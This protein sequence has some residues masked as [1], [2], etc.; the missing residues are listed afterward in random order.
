MIVRVMSKKM[1]AVESCKEDQDIAKK[2]KGGARRT[3]RAVDKFSTLAT[4]ELIPSVLSF[5]P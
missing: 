1:K 3:P 4:D 5:S 2:Y